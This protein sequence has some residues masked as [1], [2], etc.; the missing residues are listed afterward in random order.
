MTMDK[1][2]KRILVIINPAAG[3]GQPVLHTLN[4]V[5]AD[6]DIEWEIAVTKKYGD[7]GEAARAAAS[8]MDVIVACGGDGTVME[9]ANALHGT[10]TPLAVLPGGTANVLAA[11]LN[12]PHDLEQ[13]IRLITDPSARTC[14][15]DM[16]E[17]DGRLFFHLSIGILGELANRT[18]RAAK[19]HNGLLAYLLSGLKELQKLPDPT[20]FRLTLDGEKTEVEGIG[21]MVTN[22]SKIGIAD[23]RLARDIEL[24]DG[25]MDV[26]VIRDVNLS[27]L[28]KTLGEAI[29]SGE[30]ANTLWRQRA[31]EVSISVPS[32][33]HA[34]LDG[35]PFESTSES[36][37]VHT[38]P[39]AVNIFV[40][41]DDS[42]R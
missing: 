25:A 9:V 41:S 20:L 23:L 22:L 30:I 35:E 6:T 15:V 37:T 14:P 28:V 24:S 32:K 5:F 3:R 12:I 39:G 21:C 36:F 16:G 19:D 11:E 4:H 34:M 26:M 8:D 18:D 17:I 38:V 31:K 2:A 29:T 1:A 33:M 40:P 27:T 7:A 13:A 42:S 10:E